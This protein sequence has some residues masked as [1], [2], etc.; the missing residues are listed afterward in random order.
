MSTSKV[1]EELVNNKEQKTQ[2]PEV[3]KKAL[4]VGGISGALV[5]GFAWYWFGA[6]RN[7][8]LIAGLI[9]LGTTVGWLVAVLLNKRV[10]V[11]SLIRIS[12]RIDLGLAVL[13]FLMA[14]A[15][16]IG[17]VRTGEVVGIVGAFFFAFCG[18]Y[19]IIKQKRQSPD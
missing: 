16:V 17:F 15:G 9:V 1:T 11:D 14:V 4:I 7:Y 19:L 3:Y 12:A 2:I 5:A 13:S 10:P 6:S 8:I 18:M